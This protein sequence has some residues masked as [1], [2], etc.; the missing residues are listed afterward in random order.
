MLSKNKKKFRYFDIFLEI[1]DTYIH[2]RY[3]KFSINTQIYNL[4]TDPNS[5]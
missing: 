1:K 3:T 2:M 5:S 4:L